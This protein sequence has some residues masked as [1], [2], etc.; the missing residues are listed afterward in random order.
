[1]AAFL[2]GHRWMVKPLVI[3]ALLF[4]GRPAGGAVEAGDRET[5]QRLI[6]RH[7]PLI[8]FIDISHNIV[9]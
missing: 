2:P 9:T 8:T 1:M 3:V 7:V 4:R 5:S 6:D